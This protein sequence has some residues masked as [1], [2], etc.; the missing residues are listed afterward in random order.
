MKNIH[1][2][3]SD[4]QKTDVTELQKRTEV[5]NQEKVELQY[6]KT[7]ELKQ[8]KWDE[9]K[10]DLATL[11]MINLP[12]VESMLSSVMG[13]YYNERGKQGE[14]FAKI[15]LEE[16][17]GATVTYQSEGRQGPDILAKSAGSAFMAIEVK[18]LDSGE[19]FV[20]KLGETDHGRQMSDA[21]LNHKGLNPE[22]TRILLV[23]NDTQKQTFSIYRRVDSDAKVWKNLLNNAPMHKYKQSAS[24]DFSLL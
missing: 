18:T 23:V 3:N 22:S 13:S 7:A 4:Q 15:V 10:D 16:Y 21:W 20:R 9:I 8:K 2:R 17:G 11:A 14:H 5:E 12:L 19:D 24:E 1:G 6:K